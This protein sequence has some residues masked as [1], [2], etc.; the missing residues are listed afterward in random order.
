MKKALFI[1]LAL[2]LF[3]LIGFNNAWGADVKIS[4]VNLSNTSR[5][6][7]SVQ[8]ILENILVLKLDTLYKGRLK[9]TPTLAGIITLK[10]R[11]DDA[12]NISSVTISSDSTNDKEFSKQVENTIK[13]VK[14]EPSFDDVDATYSITFGNPTSTDNGSSAKDKSGGKGGSGK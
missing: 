14:F 6:I 1:T 13:T 2:L 8:N 10:M 4:T 5:D 3:G 12:G 9:T 11:I 7:N